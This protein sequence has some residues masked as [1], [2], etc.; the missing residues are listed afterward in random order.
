MKGKHLFFAFG[1]LIFVCFV[2]S[3]TFLSLSCFFIESLRMN[4][5]DLI[6]SSPG[7]FLLFALI[8]L[9]LGFFF[10]AGFYFLYHRK[11]MRMK[12]RSF[13][14]D[15][16]IKVMEKFIS[17]FFKKNY[18]FRSFRVDIL[19]L[20]RG[21]L[22]IV[23]YVADLHPDEKQALVALVKDELTDFLKDKFGYEKPFFLSFFPG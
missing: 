15:M 20:P 14:C 4:F 16:D 5:A 21:R 13:P 22:E 9:V 8:L 12:I 3:L 19:G 2:F 11:N 1:S 18:P 23:A 6:L 17:Q 7:I 10:L